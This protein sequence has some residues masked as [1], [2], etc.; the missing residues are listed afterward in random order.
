MPLLH[1]LQN[2]IT[3]CDQV[4][5]EIKQ[6]GFNNAPQ[7]CEIL[8][9]AT[10]SAILN[11]IELH[12]AYPSNIIPQ[13]AHDGSDAADFLLEH[14][15]L[16]HIVALY[17]KIELQT[18][19]TI[20]IPPFS[21]G[22]R[23]G[24]IKKPIDTIKI[25]KTL[26]YY[27]K[28]FNKFLISPD[29]VHNTSESTNSGHTQSFSFITRD[30]NP[31][32]LTHFVQNNMFFNQYSMNSIT[33]FSHSQILY[34]A[35]SLLH[36][37]SLF[38][39]VYEAFVDE[40][41]INM[42][43]IIIDYNDPEH[44]GIF[45]TEESNSNKISA[46]KQF[47]P[48][49]PQYNNSIINLYMTMYETLSLGY[50]AVYFLIHSLLA[51]GHH[52]LAFN[53]FLTISCNINLVSFLSLYPTIPP[54]EFVHIQRIITKDITNV[55][56]G[57]SATIVEMDE[58][59]DE[60]EGEN[61][62]FESRL[63]TI[64][65]QQNT[66]SEKTQFEHRINLQ[67]LHHTMSTMIM[68]NIPVF[69]T[70]PL[71]S[72]PSTH[73]TPLQH[74][75]SHQPAYLHNNNNDNDDL[76][77]KRSNHVDLNHISQS[78]ELYTILT[79]SFG[80]YTNILFPD[81][82]L[83]KSVFPPAPQHIISQPT[84]FLP[85]TVSTPASL[86]GFIT[87]TN[88]ISVG[89]SFIDMGIGKV[90][91]VNDANGPFT[92]LHEMI[93]KNELFY[94][95]STLSTQPYLLE[96]FSNDLINDKRNFPNRSQ[97]GEELQHELIPQWLYDTF[98]IST[99]LSYQ[100]ISKNT[101]EKKYKPNP[102]V[103]LNWILFFNLTTIFEQ[104]LSS[105]VESGDNIIFIY[106]LICLITN[107]FNG[108]IFLQSEQMS[109]GQRISSPDGNDSA[110]VNER[111]LDNHTK[112]FLN[113]LE[114]TNSRPN[115]TVSKNDTLQFITGL[116][117]T[118]L[119]V[120]PNLFTQ[121]QSKSLLLV[122]S[123]EKQKEIIK[124]NNIF[125]DENNPKKHKVIPFIN[126]SLL[127]MSMVLSITTIN[128]PGKDSNA[129]PSSLFLA[130]PAITPLYYSSPFFSTFSKRFKTANP[131]T[132]FISTKFNFS[133]IKAIIQIFSNHVE[134]NLW[135]A[136]QTK[137]NL[138]RDEID[139][140]NLV[141]TFP[142]ITTTIIHNIIQSGITAPIQHVLD[143]LIAHQITTNNHPKFPIFIQKTLLQNS[144]ISNSALLFQTLFFSLSPSLISS[145]LT[146]LNSD[147]EAQPIEYQSHP[148]YIS[149]VV[150][151]RRLLTSSD[152]GFGVSNDQTKV[153][154]I[155]NLIKK[156]SMGKHPA[157]RWGQIIAEKIPKNIVDI[158]QN[159]MKTEKNTNDNNNINICDLFYNIFIGQCIEIIQRHD[160]I[161]FDTQTYFT[162]QFHT[163][164]TTLFVSLELLKIVK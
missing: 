73:F 36:S 55:E 98:F 74:M 136:D 99:F 24:D 152:D 101:V 138:T 117:L 149:L 132:H 64:L 156:F 4:S 106:F 8:P 71:P 150:D 122:P 20:E 146:S 111:E 94:L 18:P 10:P 30:I 72:T 9:P 141:I 120:F 104:I 35:Q 113:Y 60:N 53:C 154:P 125:I 79:S 160:S 56:S 67:V 159:I 40:A 109:F 54:S 11:S 5:D 81:E 87:M 127:A 157:N 19:N 90:G 130:K 34:L 76:I 103:N 48:F 89:F 43:K 49:N 39:H 133:F 25:V 23:D 119:D 38:N 158:L 1:E 83:Q 37:V 95:F 28:L 44:V 32:K 155:M 112:P 51:S 62:Q 134:R 147:V 75:L 97:V 148:L 65:H 77:K 118:I 121:F 68:T 63:A 126:P 78:P 61:S 33:Q 82:I 86:R 164:M 59:E 131:R 69:S 137:T 110:L 102:F 116:V 129:P 13:V 93:F 47:Y 84:F 50:S 52:A 128:T 29:L 80:Q 162:E 2:V 142:S 27:S 12:H 108:Q 3:F 139:T 100:N 115:Q 107:P 70:S 135:S 42:G 41:K 124:Q 105:F 46:T 151:A 21:T 161:M 26:G 163:A 143:L 17:P 58:N 114:S 22:D 91:S 88:L 7:N 66:S 45:S 92:T 153:K 31:H 145:L 57:R 85:D 6:N 140:T 15:Q 14:Q 96:N 144:T 123:Y 16:T